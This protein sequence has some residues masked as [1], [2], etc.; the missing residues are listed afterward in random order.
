VLI[1]AMAILIYTLP[2][3]VRVSRSPEP[4]Q[5]LLPL[6]RF[7]HLFIYLAVRQRGACYSAYV[8]GRGQFM[9]LTTLPS[10]GAQICMLGSRCLYPLTHLMYSL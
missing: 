5:H 2:N 3:S 10:C 8:D 7:M 9:R 6:V 1:S 4:F